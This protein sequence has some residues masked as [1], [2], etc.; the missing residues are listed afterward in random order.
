MY[1]VSTKP[2]GFSIEITNQDSSL[3]MTGVRIMLGT[4]DSQRA[5]SYVEVHVFLSFVVS[6]MNYNE[7]LQVQLDEALQ[8]LLYF[9][10]HVLSVV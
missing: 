8:C 5:P 3:V 6:R 2:A 7:G 4:Q 1:V 9:S 10:L